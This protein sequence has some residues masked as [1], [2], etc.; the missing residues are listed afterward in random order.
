MQTETA[1]EEPR[2]SAPV[3]VPRPH[4]VLALEAARPLAR[5]ARY[6]LADV[7]RVTI[8]RGKTRAASRRVSGGW[9]ELVVR[10][11]A[12]AMSSVHAH[13]VRERGEWVVEDAGSR[14]G[15]RVN[16]VRST[17]DALREGDALEL[18]GAFFFV[19]DAWLTDASRPVD[20]DGDALTAARVGLRTL[21]PVLAQRSEEL[22]RIAITKVA[23]VIFGETGTG[24]EVM[25]RAIHEMS[26]RSGPF[27]AVNCGALPA[28]LVEAML[29]GHSRGAFSGAVRDELGFVR[30]A[31]GGTLFLD[32]I[33]D[34]PGPS[35]A[36]L[37]RVLQEGEVVPIGTTRPLRVDIRVVA[38]THRPLD[39]LVT[40]GQFRGDLL[41]R[42][43]G[44]RLTLDPLRERREDIGIIIAD[45]L[46]RIAGDRAH[47]IT[48]APRTAR[49]LVL[50]PWPHNIRG[51]EQVLARAIALAD[52]GNIRPEHLPPELQ[53]PG[54]AA[55]SMVPPPLAPSF[56]SEL[57]D[58]PDAA[59]R[60]ALVVQ[61]EAHHGNVAAVARVM[62]RAPMQVRRWMKYW[63]I[64]A[65]RFR[66]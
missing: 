9:N 36:A 20:L 25:A 32:E 29:F 60:A 8:G 62:G 54:E 4:L 11:P 17:R 33:G 14:N 59:L 38:A 47:A 27:I 41:A 50:A 12:Q 24:K 44:F 58:D 48:F 53:L 42:L 63:D 34:L 26:G 3:G 52:D 13:I 66:R 37:L 21:S 7:D 40:S 61:L 56:P 35:Q 64:D 19:R 49:A 23:V 2:D 43:S 31:D 55:D 15:T 22:A 57:L 10:V 6:S 39:D 51:L 18:G 28:T 5:G 16:G 65:D 45:L 46:E 30:A 1:E